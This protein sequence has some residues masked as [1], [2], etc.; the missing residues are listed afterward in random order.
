MRSNRE[1]P[2][3]VLD[4]NRDVPATSP[5]R[6]GW[7]R[8]RGDRG[9]RHHRAHRGLPAGRRRQTGRRARARSMCPRRHR[10]HQRPSHDD[11]RHAPARSWCPGSG[12]RTPRRC[13]TRGWPPS[14]RSTRSC[15]PTP[16][17]PTSPGWTAT[18]TQQPETIGRPRPSRSRTT[19][20]LRASSASTS[21][22][23]QRRRSSEARACSSPIRRAFI[24][25]STWRA[26]LA[27]LPPPPAASTSTAQPP[28]SRTRRAP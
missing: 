20:R 13:G 24:L 27:P 23:W 26:W 10:L 12:N 25:G 19:K 11:H 9:R 16:S 2:T 5:A 28:S 6:P 1:E 8:R 17:T 18:C 21:S 3:P 14:A 15:A 4:V 7:P 22:S